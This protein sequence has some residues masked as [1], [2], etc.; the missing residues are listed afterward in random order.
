MTIIICMTSARL[1]QYDMLIKVVWFQAHTLE[2]EDK[3][4]VCKLDAFSFGR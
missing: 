1:M 4:M 2:I 3:L